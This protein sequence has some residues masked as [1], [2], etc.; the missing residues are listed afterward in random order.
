MGD[1]RG[2]K[3]DGERVKSV[4][5]NHH[6]EEERRSRKNC[7]FV[8]RNTPSLRGG[9]TKQVTLHPP[10]STKHQAQNINND[11]NNTT[12]EALI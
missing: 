12:Y 5:L 6:C 4:W 2:A 3:G 9:T 8:T 7:N 10:L 11:Y 1:R